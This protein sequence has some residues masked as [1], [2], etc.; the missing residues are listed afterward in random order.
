MAV[1]G[2]G[3]V[4]PFLSDSEESEPEETRPGGS[5]SSDPGGLGAPLPVSSSTSSSPPLQQQL[6]P[7]PVQAEEPPRVPVDALAAQLLRDQFVLTA[8]ELHTELLESGRELPR[9][10]DYFSNP[11]NFERQSGGGTGA[12]APTPS[13]SVVPGIISMV[14][15]GK[16][17]G[18][19]QLHRAGS[20]STLDSLDFARYSD[21]GN[22][23]TDERVAVLEFE[24]RKAKETIQALRANLTQAAEN[25]VPLQERRN[26]KS[27]PEIQVSNQKY[28]VCC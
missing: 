19:G 17:P 21:D 1:V 4:N 25:E 26:Y 18:A 15:G 10:R 12:L 22:R 6:L 23:E 3:G 24:L 9:L 11:G 27:S 20:I 5:N 7:P 28:C 14:G 8:L 13:A 16:E 2:G